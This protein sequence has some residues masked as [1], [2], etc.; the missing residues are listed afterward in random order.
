[1]GRRIL[2]IIISLSMVLAV[3]SGCA[4]GQETETAQDN[5]PIYETYKDIPGITDEEIAAVD[6]LREEYSCFY[7]AMNLSTEAFTDEN[8]EVSGFNALMCQWMSDFFKIPFKSELKEWEALITGLDS[9]QVDFT[10]ELTP[11]E[12]RQKKYFMTKPIAERSLKYFHLEESE[13]LTTIAKERTLNYAFLEGATSIQYVREKA[14]EEYTETYVQ[15][16]DEALRLLREGKIDAFF[17][18]G[19]AE[20]AFDK[21]LDIAAAQYYPLV[22]TP[23]A[24]STG[25]PEL[26]PI[27]DIMNKYLDNDGIYYLTDLYNQG[28]QQYRKHKLEVQLTDEEKAYL[29]EHRGDNP[30]PLAAE[31]DNY[32]SSFYNDQEEE[33][34]GIAFDV[35]DEISILTGLEFVPTNKPD[36]SWSELLHGLERG[37]TAVITEL[38]PSEER[39][40]K[41][42][43]VEGAYSEDNYALVSRADQ[44][45][46]R[47]NQILYSSVAIPEDTAFEEVFNQWFPSHQNA[48]I[49]PSTDE[50]FLALERGD[51]DFVMASRNL[52]L[53]MTNYSEKTGFRVN[54]LFDST[55]ES[56]FGLNKEEKVLASIMTK[57]QKLVDVEAITDNWTHRVFDYQSKLLQT[58][59]PYLIGLTLL[60]IL[61]IGLMLML[62]YRGNKSGQKLER[63]VKERTA[64]LEIQTEAARQASK[65]K[66]EFLSRMSHEIRTPLN[67]IIGMAQVEKQIP[68]LPAK[69]EETNDEII[70]ASKHLLDVLND[71]LDM[72]KIESGKFTMVEEPFNLKGMMEEIVGIIRQ[73]CIEKSIQ[74]NSNIDGLDDVTLM[75]DRLRL[76]QI[77]INLLGNAV[78]FTDEN[79]SI[80]FEIEQRKD[81][82]DAASFLF[83]VKDDGIGMTE[84]QLSH[85]F[86]AFEQA[87]ETVAAR[88]GGTGLGLAISQS[89]VQKMG[90]DIHVE[91]QVDEGS[92]FW[93]E[94]SLPVVD[95]IEEDQRDESV[96][97][98]TNKRILLAEDIAVNRMILKELLKETGST[99]DEAENGEIAWKMF[100]K[101]PVGYYDFIFMDIQMPEM[102]GYT[103]TESIRALDRKDARRIP[104]I[105]MTANAYREDVDR[106]LAH[107][108]SDHVAKP[109]DIGIVYRTIKKYL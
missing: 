91:S 50:C 49:Y 81:A 9:H 45:S 96:P 3:I 70:L 5:Y 89:L 59:I 106:A 10:G 102:D 25:N 53:S 84:E 67:A 11:T 46:I 31:Y 22:Y 72:S 82:S 19:T 37:D 95:Y 83:S 33:W 107:G 6:A 51:V 93:F 58:Q 94:L 55:Y 40:D 80:D 17:E 54:I 18:D 86:E 69:V 78:K 97:D 32:P 61:V 36:V 76:K 68:D 43:W 62:L 105:A 66:G 12:E 90:S 28:D 13:K 74:L 16:Y 52:M 30:I 75:G 87:D 60:L 47:V 103:A 73:R 35:L 15:D 98:L 100:K 27:I 20:A 1:M 57:A 8:G 48:V 104:I 42:I 64:E 39:R 63:M 34:Q 14:T 101:S 99:I 29:L 26:A 108:M 24:L 88:Y 7:V 2:A 4:I 92:H 23:V 44:E 38:I 79:G 77:L 41:Y 85:L 21:D 109:I 71:I 65:A 56:Q